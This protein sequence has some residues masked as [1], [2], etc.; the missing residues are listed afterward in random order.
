V[1]VALT[2]RGRHVADAALEDLLARERELLAVLDADQ[3]AELAALLR[4]LLVPFD[5]SPPPA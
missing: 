2:E 4:L 3:R 5:A 1:L